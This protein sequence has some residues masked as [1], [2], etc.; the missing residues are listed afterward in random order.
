VSQAQGAGDYKFGKGLPGNFRKRVP[1]HCDE[2]E[3][4]EDNM[5]SVSQKPL[6]SRDRQLMASFGHSEIEKEQHPIK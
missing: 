5:Y 3:E 1:T 6:A 4:E 2:E